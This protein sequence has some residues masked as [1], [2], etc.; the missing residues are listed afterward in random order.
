[1]SRP[2]G[3]LTSEVT[4]AESGRVASETNRVDYGR[5]SELVRLQGEKSGG[6]SAHPFSEIDIL[7]FSFPAFKMRESL[8]KSIRFVREVV[9]SERRLRRIN[10]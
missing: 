8:T 4:T 5:S 2:V 9:T 7:H 6:Y 1:M 3:R 10:I